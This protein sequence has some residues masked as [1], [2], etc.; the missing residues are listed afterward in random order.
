MFGETRPEAQ[1]ILVNPNI[2]KTFALDYS[3]Q[4]LAKNEDAFKNE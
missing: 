3:V 4:N 1:D 2:D